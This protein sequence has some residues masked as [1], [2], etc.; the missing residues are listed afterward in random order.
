MS[1]VLP[2]QATDVIDVDAYEDDD[3]V[4]SGFTRTGLYPE[5]QRNLDEDGLVYMGFSLS[6][7][8]RP[9]SRRS[10]TAASAQAGPSTSTRAEEVIVLDSDDEDVIMS[11]A[12]SGSSGGRSRLISPPPPPPLRG[13]TPAVPSLPRHLVSQASFPVRRRPLGAPAGPPPPIIRPS[14][15]PLP[16]ESMASLPRL[17][18]RNSSV[19]AP[20]AAPRSHHQPAMGFGGAI[21]ALNRQSRIAEA[22][23]Q[24][25]GEQPRNHF[26]IP[27]FAE[28]YR[29][30]SSYRQ[31]SNAPED[32]AGVG[33]LR[34]WQRFWPFTNEDAP[35]DAG[36]HL[37]P[38]PDEDPYFPDFEFQYPRIKVPEKPVHY[39]PSYTHPDKVAPGFTY[40]FAP[41][42]GPPLR[43]TSPTD[44][45]PSSASSSSSSAAAIETTLV[46]AR[47]LDPLV[48]AAP[49]GAPEEVRKQYRVWA[50]RCGH[51]LD[52]KCI[53]DLIT[54]PPPVPVEPSAEEHTDKG[55]GKARADPQVFTAQSCQREDGQSADLAAA[56]STTDRKGKRKAAEPLEP[57]EPPKRPALSDE[58][59]E[60]N[61]IRSRLRSRA[62]VAA[63]VSPSHAGEGSSSV[64]V[65]EPPSRQR[66]G[67]RRGRGP[68]GIPAAEFAAAYSAK[69]KGKARARA[70]AKP[71]IEA[72][73][74]WRCPIAGCTR[75]HYSVLVEGEWRNDEGRGA[76]ALFV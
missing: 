66:G 29:R 15:Q 57:D 33:G 73:H 54:P 10:H 44:A 17:P 7:S 9:A 4:F 61:S 35:Q 46:C 47:C 40:D 62:R 60:D 25:R 45:G 65:P 70:P 36:R 26:N 53:A 43:E 63:D 38:F 1:A 32:T 42:D 50:L 3:V 19:P 76:I 31:N 71:V 48:L 74:G 30:I 18:P 11:S 68:P 64:Q 24:Q 23:R 59:A 49:E 28:I 39:R 75:L 67:R 69:G 20:A 2:P 12:A 41:V 22:N 34:R 58:P 56:P 21:L 51:M 55:K 6:S 8:S 5:R 27:S 13:H 37:S 52:G 16:F 14:D 72:E